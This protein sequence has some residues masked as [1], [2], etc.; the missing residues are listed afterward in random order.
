[1]VV[2]LTLLALTPAGADFGPDE[3]GRSWSE[4]NLAAR[5]VVAMTAVAREWKRTAP[6]PTFDALLTHRTCF[7]AASTGEFAFHQIDR[8]GAPARPVL[9]RELDMPPPTAC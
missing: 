7:G 9:E 4:S 8:A 3:R 6:L 2:I 1:M 5:M